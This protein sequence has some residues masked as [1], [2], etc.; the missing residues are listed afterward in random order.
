MPTQLKIV[1]EPG[2][3]QNAPFTVNFAAPVIIKPGQK[4]ALDKFTAIVNGITTNFP[5]SATQ[6]DI[7]YSVNSP[8]FQK[9]TIYMPQAFYSNVSQLLLDM[10]R[11]IND[12]IISFNPLVEPQS[13]ITRYYR[14]RG[15][16]ILT[17]TYKN[18]F[19]IEY[20]TVPMTALNLTEEGLE[21][22]AS[23]FYYPTDVNYS[24]IQSNSAN[25]LLQGGGAM[26]EFQFRAPTV[27]Q[28]ETDG[29]SFQIGLFNSSGLGNCHGLLG[30]SDGSLWLCNNGVKTVEIPPIYFNDVHVVQIYQENGLFVLR[31]LNRDID[32]AE[33][34]IFLSSDVSEGGLGAWEIFESYVFKFE[35]TAIQTTTEAPALGTAVQMTIDIS[36]GGGNDPTTFQRTMAIDMTLSGAL[37]A[38][39]DVPPGIIFLT[40]NTSSYGVY[41]STTPINMSVVN[42]SFDLAIEVLDL[43]LQTYSA[44][45]NGRSGERNN[46]ISYFHPELSTVGSQTYIYDSKA[47]LWLDIDITYPVNL[48]SM[49]FRV[50]NPETNIDLNAQNMSFNLIVSDKEY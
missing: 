37:R 26:I 38:G 29:L 30:E 16:K 21:P 40:P 12:A 22:D 48:S 14:D 3:V 19:A 11:Y 49:S 24:S 44:S 18:A 5:F 41:Q 39:L 4:I 35:G 27:L 15:L 42:S 6:F 32:G 34:T 46:I 43:P 33:E 50:Y 45:S 36:S 17:A 7:Y 47:Y 31:V 10:T 28:S 20:L 23:G 25:I 2:Y 1:V 13:G 8:N 9:Q